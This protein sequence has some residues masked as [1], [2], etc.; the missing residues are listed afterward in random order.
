MIQSFLHVGNLVLLISSIPS[1]FFSFSVH[2]TNLCSFE[3]SLQTHALKHF[4]TKSYIG[5]F[6]YFF[7]LFVYIVVVFETCSCLATESLLSE[8]AFHI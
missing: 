7:C 3:E 8:I 5:H 4:G 6:D 2:F 1:V